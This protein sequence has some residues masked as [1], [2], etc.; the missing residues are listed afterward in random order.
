MGALGM[1][2]TVGRRIPHRHRRG[3]S[4]RLELCALCLGKMSRER[5]WNGMLRDNELYALTKDFLREKLL[6]YVPFNPKTRAR[7][8]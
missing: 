8:D 4:S 6:G 2:S 3:G 7:V 5:L 1:A